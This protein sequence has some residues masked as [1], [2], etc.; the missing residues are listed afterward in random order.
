[1]MILDTNVLSEL[2]TRRPAASVMAWA[3]MQRRSQ[4]VTTSI[5]IMELYSGLHLLKSG[6][7]RSELAT[8]I[9]WAID[10][11]LDGRILNFDRSAGVAASQLY[12]KRREAGRSIEVRDTMV[13]GIAQ[14]RRIPIATRNIGHFEGLD[15][16]VIDPW[17]PGG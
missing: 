6:K 14:A 4:M 15:V 16:K 7:R 1:M 9:E 17:S 12:A 11:L 3:N 8:D 2:M 5:T 13:A 10:D